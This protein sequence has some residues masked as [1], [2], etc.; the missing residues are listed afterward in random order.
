MVHRSEFIPGEGRAGAQGR[1]PVLSDSLLAFEGSPGSSAAAL[2]TVVG[3][4]SQIHPQNSPLS[5]MLTGQSD[6]GSFPIQ[7]LISDDTRLCQDDN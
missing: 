4:L 2:L 3:T 1:S 6:L 7:G 5:D